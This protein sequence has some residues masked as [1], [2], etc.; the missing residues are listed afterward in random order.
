MSVYD[1]TPTEGRREHMRERKTCALCGAEM[2]WLDWAWCPAPNDYSGWAYM[3]RVHN[4]LCPF[5]ESKGD[6]R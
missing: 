1:P 4:P 2:D 5:V 6:V 3:R